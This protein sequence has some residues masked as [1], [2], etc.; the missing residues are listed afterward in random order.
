MTSP[1][2]SFVSD[3]EVAQ[4]SQTLIPQGQTS[5]FDAFIGPE[6]NAEKFGSLPEQVLAGAEGFA[7][8]MVTP[9]IAKHAETFFLDNDQEQQARAEANPVTAGAGEILGFGTGIYATGLAKGAASIAGKVGLSAE[10]ALGR[11]GTK[12]LTGVIENSVYSGANETAKMVFRDPDQTLGS[13]LTNVGGLNGLL[14]GALVGGALGV[15]GELWNAKFGHEVKSSLDAVHDTINGGDPN[16]PIIPEAAQESTGIKEYRP[17]AGEVLQSSDRLGIKPTRGMLDSDSIFGHMEDELAK[18]DTV[19]GRVMNNER[20]KIADSL[21]D[22]SKDLLKDAT[23]KTEPAAGKELREDIVKPLD[24]EGKGLA[25]RF[26][27]D[28]KH[29]VHMEL[30]PEAKA[31][32]IQPILNHPFVAEFPESSIAKHG[33]QIAEDISKLQNV[34]SVKIYRTMLNGELNKSV[35]AGDN[36]AISILKTAKDA[37]NEL[38]TRGIQESSLAVAGREGNKIAAKIIERIQKLDMDYAAY[39]SKVEQV[40]NALGLGKTKNIRGLVDKMDR[41]SFKDESLP[42]KIFDVDNIEKTKFFKDNFNKQY[43]LARQS[44]LKDI[45]E[46]SID[47]TQGK[48]RNF[49]TQKFLS[50]ISD[51]RMNPEAREM[52][53]PGM[54][55]KI[56]DL[57]T[58]QANFPGSFNTSNTAAALGFFNKLG[59]NAIDLGKLGLSKVANHVES[60]SKNGEAAQIATAKVLASGNVPPSSS[61]FKAMSDY[62]AQAI[63]G[64]NLIGKAVRAIFHG[65]S[66]MLP[67]KLMPSDEDRNKLDKKLLSLQSNPNPL[68]DV[69]GDLGHY[70]PDHSVGLAKTASSAVSYLNSIRP[71]PMSPNPLDD[72]IPVSKVAQEE[73]NNALDIANQPLIVLEK[74]KNGTLTPK[75]ME[76]LTAI[77]PALHTKLTSKL[78]EQVIDAVHDKLDIPYATKMSL[79]LFTGQPLDSTMTPQGIMAAQ[80]KPEQVAQQQAIKQHQN[81]HG[82]MKNINKLAQGMATPDQA[83]SLDRSTN[84]R[85]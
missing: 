84:R 8:G 9:T 11:I 17:G 29:F 42:S 62:I 83:R 30:S 46:K 82:S 7:R 48:G 64:E 19:A 58:V 79:A 71:T 14:G 24:A 13:A 78:T 54:A 65:G 21:A 76:H 53:F 56:R 26:D 16:A 68:F 40:G 77:Y 6:L 74:V 41:L 55:E 28:K 43:E 70:L 51:R 63:K 25:E 85:A 44:K 81:G 37:L 20:V 50:Q 1:F 80:P 73:F 27:A 52:L 32:A 36:N 49:S 60:L 2:D 31:D 39:K 66:L 18:Q 67:A 59:Q 45:Y 10:S 3:A 34:N 61:A 33:L 23:E 57:R 69:A 4:P 22:H 12:A 35:L 38:R 15:G 75:D 47:E 5:P 72:E